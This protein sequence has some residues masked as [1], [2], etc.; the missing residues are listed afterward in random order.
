[1]KFEKHKRRNQT[2]RNLIIIAVGFLATVMAGALVFQVYVG[3]ME[4]LKYKKV[5]L[6]IES[7]IPTD[8][9]TYSFKIANDTIFS[10]KLIQGKQNIEIPI[11]GKSTKSISFSIS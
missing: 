2:N 11:S 9:L 8:T 3:K 6:E 10:N 5:Y 4:N 1:M 7:Q